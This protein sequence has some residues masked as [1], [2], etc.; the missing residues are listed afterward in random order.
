MLHH[1]LDA[2]A[3]HGAPG[4]VFDPD[5]P[6]M[7]GRKV[8]IEISD[9]G[10]S[11][12]GMLYNYEN[13]PTEKQEVL[14]ALA[15]GETPYAGGRCPT[16]VLVHN[17][18]KKTV[19]AAR[20][21]PGTRLQ[22]MATQSAPLDDVQQILAQ[23]G[24][25]G[26]DSIWNRVG[27]RLVDAF[28]IFDKNGDGWLSPAEMGEGLFNLDVG[29]AKAQIR[30]LVRLADVDRDGKIQYKE[31]LAMFNGTRKRVV[32]RPTL[33]VSKRPTTRK[34]NPQV[35]TAQQW[36]REIGRL[37]AFEAMHGPTLDGFVAS[38]HDY[39]TANPALDWGKTLL[40]APQFLETVAVFGRAVTV[41]P[42]RGHGLAELVA[43][44]EANYSRRATGATLAVQSTSDKTAVM[45]NKRMHAEYE[46]TKMVE[47]HEVQSEELVLVRQRS[48]EVRTR[49]DG[50]MRLPSAEKKM[51]PP[52]P[53]D[54][55]EMRAGGRGDQRWRGDQR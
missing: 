42:L 33:Q 44:V 5:R 50:L 7:S 20:G 24:S 55:H 36:S 38:W 22:S 28:R 15:R 47:L 2:V 45:R 30:K 32:R 52:P 12:D 11:E 27:L 25:G 49:L 18:R 34:P 16:S 26:R 17:K 37:P 53:R 4:G 13:L 10:F 43:Q 41:R 8:R 35:L 31:F 9:N 29:L 40:T 48:H 3:G 19:A 1:V 51:P 21:P 23:F 54:F 39:A 6:L 46:R 14:A